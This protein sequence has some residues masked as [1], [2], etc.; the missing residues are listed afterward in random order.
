MPSWDTNKHPDTYPI[1]WHEVLR[2]RESGEYFLCPRGTASSRTFTNKFCSF[3]RALERYPAHPTT[4]AMVRSGLKPRLSF[5]RQ[6][7]VWVRMRPEGLGVDLEKI[8]GL[9]REEK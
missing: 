2:V 6:G 1:R 8:L 7:D 4:R 9:E 3:L 5:K